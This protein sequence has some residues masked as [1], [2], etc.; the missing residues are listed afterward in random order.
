MRPRRLM[1]PRTNS[2]ARGTLVISA[3]RLISCTCF[4]STPYSSRSRKN[5]ARCS[6]ASAA[7][8]CC[9]AGAEKNDSVCSRP[10]TSSAR[11][12]AG[13]AV[14]A[15]ASAAA[16]RAERHALELRQDVLGETGGRQHDGRAARA[17]AGRAPACGVFRLVGEHRL[18]RGRLRFRLRLR[19]AVG[20]GTDGGTARR[21]RFRASAIRPML[22][23]PRAPAGAAKSLSAATVSTILS[24]TC[25]APRAIPSR[26][27]C[28]ASWL[29]TRGTPAAA[30]CSRAMAASLKSGRVGAGH[31][32]AGARRRR[33]RP[34]PRAARGRRTRRS[35]A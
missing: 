2:G 20:S 13:S 29:S 16:P 28:V 17:G 34:R 26:S 10:R 35:A 3:T 19:L 1:T 18:A 33:A 14:A 6:V 15:I 31:A 7:A 9:C 24:S 23:Y 30:A 27:A 8:R 32:T 5:V 12:E 25:A 4:T 21:A 22:V 11:P